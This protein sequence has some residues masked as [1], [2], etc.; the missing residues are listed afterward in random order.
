MK[1][2]T[3][4]AHPDD[5][6]ISMF[7]IL[8]IYHERGYKI[9]N[10]IATDGSKGAKNPN[11]KLPEIRKN[12]TRDG[13]GFLGDLFFLDFPDGELCQYTS[14]I[15][16]LKAMLNQIN[17]NLIITHSPKDYHT[18]HRSLSNFVTEAADFTCPVLFCDTML[19]VNFY[20]EFYVDITNYFDKKI[21]AIMCHNSQNPEKYVNSVKILNGFRAA[22]CNS[23]FDRY[24]EAYSWEKRFPFSDIRELIP[25]APRIQVL[26]Y[27]KNKKK[28][29]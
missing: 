15:S 20:P 8:S 1:I 28:L 26:N 21:R 12:E 3:I 24:A 27:N 11:K 7:G 17:P 25:P 5:I 13:I 10:I 6:E 2:L 14:I 9:Y 23:S 4:S 18:D 19:G 29:I 22:Q 16:K